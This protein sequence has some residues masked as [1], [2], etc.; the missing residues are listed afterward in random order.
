MEIYLTLSHGRIEKAQF[1][2]DF[3]SMQEPETLAARLVGCRPDGEDY[4]R[5]LEQVD[6]SA[7]FMGMT[8][9]QLLQLLEG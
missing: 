9:D 3:F 1:H 8:T 4:R 6:V 7:Y 2:G 5:A